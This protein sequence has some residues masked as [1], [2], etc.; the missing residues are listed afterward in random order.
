MSR[1]EMRYQAH[2]GNKTFENRHVCLVDCS[3]RLK[4]GCCYLHC[5]FWD[6]QRH[7]CAPVVMDIRNDVFHVGFRM[8]DMKERRMLVGLNSFVFVWFSVGS[9][10]SRLLCSVRS[11]RNV[12]EAAPAAARAAAAIREGQPCGHKM[13]INQASQMHRSQVWRRAS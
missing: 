4:A 6:R 8:S 7:F 5:F 2:F 1:K 9:C 3:F 11:R 13:K 12:R 10:S